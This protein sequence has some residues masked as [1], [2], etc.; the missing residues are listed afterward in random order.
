MTN[1]FSKENR[2]IYV[3]DNCDAQFLKWN[4]R[5]LECGKWGSLKSEFQEDVS[6]KEEKKKEVPAEVLSLVDLD[7]SDL[8]RIETGIGEVDRVLGGGVV[9]GSLLILSGEPGVGK[10][11]LVAQIAD[12]VSQGKP[13]KKVVYVSGEESFSQVGARLNRLN[14]GASDIKFIS[15]TNVEKIL[16]GIEQIQ[17]DL[18]IID[19]IQTV[20]TRDTASDAGGVNQIRAC[21][22]KFLEMA[23]KDNIAT[24]LIG[25]ITKDGQVAGPKSLEHIVDTVLSL[26]AGPSSDHLILR[27]TKNRFGSI[28]EIGVF[29]MKSSGFQEV[30]NP[31]SVFLESDRPNI[32]GSV[33]SCVL[34][35]KRPFLVDIQ[36]LVTKTAFGYPQRRASGIDV[37]RLQILVAVLSKRTK[38][39]LTNQDIVLNVVGGL[40]INDTSLDLAICAAM[41]TSLLNQPMNKKTIVMGEVGLGGEV[42]MVSR[43]ESRLKEAEN[44]G[45]EKAIVPDGQLK[46][47]KIE[48]NKVSE[49]GDI[50]RLF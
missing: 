37:N 35:G 26:E 45:F 43:L 8:V 14:C 32:P 7:N 11:T 19:S 27:A 23:K 9:S 39:N 41:I 1:K 4:G 29:E 16:A 22:T 36:A 31:S 40:R 5:C 2:N 13:V 33:I 20:Y 38:I 28:D 46:S 50:L 44:L 42:R 48:L 3:C 6:R 25:H 10:S 47:K 12:R 34:E 17:P 18:V 30:P 24:V 49:V 15:E 21:A